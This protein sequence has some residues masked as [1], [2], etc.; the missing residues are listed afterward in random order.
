M[1]E[2]ALGIEVLNSYKPIDEKKLEIRKELV[3]DKPDWN[4]V[5]KLNTEIANEHGRMRTS[6]MKSRVE[7]NQNLANKPQ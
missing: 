1:G 3:K 5:E 2:T 7:Y 6:V 4:R